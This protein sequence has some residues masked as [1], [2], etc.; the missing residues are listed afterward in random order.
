M[1]F[2]EALVVGVVLGFSLAA[3]PGPVL[4]QLAFE[5]ARGRW[6]VGFLVGLGATTADG[7][8]FLLTWLG[9]AT[10]APSEHVTAGLALVGAGLMTFF[11]YDA[12]R[13]AR[14]P[15]QLKAGWLT[16]F[17]AGFLLAA[18]SPFNLA[19][20]VTT[21]STMLGIYGATL[22]LGFFLAI[23]A[24]VAASVYIVHLGAR[25]V[26]RFETWVSYAS[27]VF[28]AGFAVFLVRHAV[29]VLS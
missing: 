4:A 13:A 24:V 18:T 22:A 28:L 17:P 27:A 10:V 5:T 8:F 19:W 12:W 15:L 2:L 14:T 26:E 16:G 7:L 6:F 9:V 21:G 29:L 1:A 23:L 20:W 25:K 3:P 11:A